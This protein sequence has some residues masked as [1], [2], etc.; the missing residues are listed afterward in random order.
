MYEFLYYRVRDVMTAAPIAVAPTTPLSEVETIF[1]QHDFNGVPVVDAAHHLLGVLT[2]LDF[3]KAFRF[4]SE[5]VVPHYEE[6]MRQPAESAM[7]RDPVTFDPDMPL[8]RVL[9]ELVTTRHKSF[10]VVAAGQL[11]GIVA[12]EDV[13]RALRKAA[14]GEGS[15]GAAQ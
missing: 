8:T 3:L 7:T 1:A 10:P 15:P 5:S 12:R 13:L 2:K 4:T 6:I 11:V 14:A 9:D